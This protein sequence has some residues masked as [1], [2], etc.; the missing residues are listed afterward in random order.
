MKQQKN[1]QLSINKFKRFWLIFSRASLQKHCNPFYL[2]PCFDCC[3]LLWIS[4]LEI[5]SINKTSQSHLW[6]QS[7]SSCRVFPGNVWI[8]GWLAHLSS[9]SGFSLYCRAG[10][11]SSTGYHGDAWQEAITLR[12][13]S[14]P[15]KQRCAK[16]LWA[17]NQ[18]EF[19]EKLQ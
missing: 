5:D 1:Y 19:K 15:N 17:T 13:P 7:F 12:R 10:Q 8:S 16:S 6:T 14:G 2:W 11:V 9:S 4:K 18:T 3:V